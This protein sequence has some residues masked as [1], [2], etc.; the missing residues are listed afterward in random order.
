VTDLDL[1]ANGVAV[2]SVTETVED[3]I[4]SEVHALV[5]GSLWFYI[6]DCFVYVKDLIIKR[7]A[8]SVLEYWIL[9]INVSEDVEH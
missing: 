4:G 3:S 5:V 2:T 9:K 6:A 7:A 8:A 1:L